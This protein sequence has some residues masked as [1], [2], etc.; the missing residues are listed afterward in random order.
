MSQLNHNY[1]GD[2]SQFENMG[3]EEQEFQSYRCPVCH[4]ECDIAIKYDYRSERFFPLD[5]TETICPN[6][7]EVY[8]DKI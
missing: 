2:K 1:V 5:I 4:Y 8:M 6:C 3:M 7:D